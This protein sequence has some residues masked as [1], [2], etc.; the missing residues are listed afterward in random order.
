[1]QTHLCSTDM[2]AIAQ[3]AAAETAA[4][5]GCAPRATASTGCSTMDASAS[6][7]LMHL[8]IGEG[9][10]VSRVVPNSVSICIW[11]ELRADLTQARVSFSQSNTNFCVKWRTRHS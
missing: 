3:P 10:S 11:H 2:Q 7:Q 6:Q 4:C 9:A 1:M 5:E 8:P